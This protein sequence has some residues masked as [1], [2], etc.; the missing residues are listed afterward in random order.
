MPALLAACAYCGSADVPLHRV[1]SAL[2]CLSCD[3]YD[4]ELEMLRSVCCGEA[5]TDDARSHCSLCLDC[6]T[7]E[8]V[9]A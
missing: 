6:T 3:P 5:P 2:A 7:F 9:A 8:L 1:G 4:V